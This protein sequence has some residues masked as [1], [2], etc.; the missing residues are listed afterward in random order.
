[1]SAKGSSG[2]NEA[3][4]TQLIH[5]TAY[6]RWEGQGRP[7]GTALD[8]WLYAEALILNAATKKPAP[9]PVPFAAASVAAGVPVK[10]KK[11]PVRH[12]VAVK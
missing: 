10:T 2:V 7:C 6:Y 3:A 9:T 12:A 1:M 11:I 8:D 5:E 4:S